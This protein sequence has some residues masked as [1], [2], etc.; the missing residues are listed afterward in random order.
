M[1]ISQEVM[2]DVFGYYGLEHEQPDVYQIL[3]GQSTRKS[4]SHSVLE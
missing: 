3:N 1:I 2:I 4:G